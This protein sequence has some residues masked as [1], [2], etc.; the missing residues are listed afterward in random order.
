MSDFRKSI[1]QGILWSVFGT[2]SSLLIVLLTNIWLARLL[3]PKEF[4]QIGIIM[5]FITLANVFT[6]SGL[7]G[8]LIRKKEATKTDYSTVF[9][10]NL[11]FSILCYAIILLTAKTIANYYDDILIDNLLIVSGLVLIINAFQLPQNAKLVSEMRFKPRAIYRFVAV[12]LSSIIGIY[13]AYRG[14]G[15]WALVLI[16]LMSAVLNTL[17]LWF[18]EGYFMSLSFSR[19]SF[20]ELY[21]FGINTTLTSILITGFDNIYQL[22]LA[23]YFSVSQTGFFYQ[24]KK[25]QDV[26]GGVINMI[27]HSVIFSSLTK[28]QDDKLAFTKAYNKIMLYFIATLGLIS[29]CIYCYA[30][31]LISIFYGR[32]W[33]GMVF[34]MQLLTIASFF[35]LQE[36]I[37]QVIFKVFN[38]TRQ[39][40]YLEYA[41][42][43]IQ[44]ISVAIGIYYRSMEILIW[45]FVFTNIIGYFTNYYFSRKVTNSVSVYEL[46]T[47]LKVITIAVFSSYIILEF[48]TLGDLSSLRSLVTIPILIIIY[49][50]GLYLFNVL[51]I[52]NEIVMV[53]NIYKKEHRY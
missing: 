9:V 1:I 27:A 3:S 47:V 31:P 35:L 33:I 36:L 22:V 2:T 25:L 44:A 5:F 37:N 7:G 12:V 10:A 45:G 39:I 15:V 43:T 21:G 38:K 48:I 30:E 26:P 52:K 49:F 40:L 41:K 28:L 23:K 4:G 29:A 50:L 51:N 24:A 11:I 32:E 16:Q 17:F 19:T 34:Y 13:F 53:W 6:E 18:F 46:F 8:A 42:K 14:I 20:K